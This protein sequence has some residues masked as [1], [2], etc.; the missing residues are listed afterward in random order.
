MAF[1]LAKPGPGETL[2]PVDAWIGCK[3]TSPNALEGS[4]DTT[5][6][7]APFKTRTTGGE[8]VIDLTP[9][10]YGWAWLITITVTNIGTYTYAVE[11]PDV[12]SIDFEDLQRLDPTTL[13]PN[14]WPDPVWWA[15]LRSG[16]QSAQPG[17]PGEQG[18]AGEKGET[19]EP[20]APGA[21]GTN[22]AAELVGVLPDAVLPARLSQTAL[23][24]EYVSHTTLATT[25][26]TL[27]AAVATK[28][29]TDD[30]AAT[31]VTFTDTD[32]DP[33][34]GKH[35]TITVNTTTNEITDILIEDN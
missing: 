24:N 10:G 8:T 30:A 15:A 12:E 11:V 16:L 21:P 14:A 19:G 17:P 22:N 31:Y 23:D 27:N 33:L 26:T 25:V 35:V 5:I 18:E 13:G 6:L 28:L 32:G 7:P 9:T 1:K 2:I 34:I 29:D 4:P 3:P 20:G